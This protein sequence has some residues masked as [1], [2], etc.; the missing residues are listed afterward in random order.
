MVLVNKINMKFFYQSIR[1]HTKHI[2]TIT[3]KFISRFLLSS[4]IQLHPLCQID[5]A[6][7]RYYRSFLNCF[8]SVW[9]RLFTGEKV[10]IFIYAPATHFFVPLFFLLNHI[11]K[12]HIFHISFSCWKFKSNKYKINHRV[13][14][15]NFFYTKLLAVACCYF[16]HSIFIIVEREIAVNY[17]NNKKW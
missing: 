12:F 16:D 9:N 17:L 7:Y 8:G 6:N 14:C 4:P 10:F 5:N 15:T 11:C 3:M 13:L 1:Y 2:F